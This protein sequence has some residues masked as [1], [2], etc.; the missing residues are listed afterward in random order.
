MLCTVAAMV[1]AARH[2]LSI[3]MYASGGRG[4]VSLIS[5]ISCCD[6]GSGC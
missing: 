3:V 1:L 6:Y 5:M 4:W 2:L